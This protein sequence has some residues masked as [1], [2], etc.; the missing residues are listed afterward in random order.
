MVNRWLSRDWMT[1]DRWTIRYGVA[2]ALSLMA[3]VLML[4][5]DPY[6]YL[7]EASFL[8]FF[9]AVTISAWYG[10][11]GPGILT[12][13][14]SALF[15]NYFFLPPLES[16]EV[17]SAGLL[18]ML[19]FASQGVLI[20][21]LVGSLR[22]TK[23]RI[24]H[25]LQQ[26]QAV[27]LA[28]R[29]SEERYRSLVSILTSIVWTVDPEGR[30]IHPQ[31][32]WKSYTGQDW[33]EHRGWGWLEAIHPGDR[34]QVEAAWK[35]AQGQQTVYHTEGRIWHQASQQYRYFEARAVPLLS[36]DGT[37]REW[38]GTVQ[39]VDDRRRAAAEI[40]QLNQT[41]QRRVDELQTLFDVIPIGIAIAEDP[42]C[43]VVR[44]NPAF[45]ALLQIELSGN[46]SRTPPTGQPTPPFKVYQNGR[47][48]SPE[49]LPQ[50]YAAK[51]GVALNEVEVDIVRNDGAAFNLYGYVAPL[52][53][54]QGQS[55]GSIAA[56]LDITDRKRAEAA[57]QQREAELRLIT[58]S[59]PALIS[60]VDT[61]R[62]YR[63]V[64]R[65]YT[66]WFGKP[67][68]AIVG[69]S[70]EDF[71]GPEI[72]PLMHPHVE[73]ALAGQRVSAE[74]LM[75]FRNG[76]PR[77]VRRQY[78]PDVDAEGRVRGFYALINDIT[79]LKQV[80]AD[81][82]KTAAWLRLSLKV[83]SMGS[84][85]WNM[86]T[87]AVTWSEGHFTILGY[88]IN[89]C[90]P[91]YAA[92]ASRVHPDD[93]KAAE[94][95]V[96]QAI[97]QHTD[98][99][100]QHR[101]VWPDGSIHWVE[102]RG[103]IFYQEDDRPER[104][105]GVLVDITE[106]KQT[107][108]I[109]ERRAE[110]MTQL[111]YLLMSATA[112]L[113]QRNQ[114][115]DQ[116]AYVVS[117]DLKAPL[118]GIVNLAEWLKEE[119][120]EQ[121]SE[122]HQHLLQ[123]MQGRASRMQ[124]LINGLLEYSRIGRD[125]MPVETVNLEDLLADLVDILDPP[126]DYKV[127]VLPPLPTLTTHP[128]LMRQVFANLISNAIK[129]CDRPDCEITI[130]ASDQGNQYEFSV[131][132][133]GPGIDPRYHQKIFGIFQTLQ[134]RDKVESTGVG[135]SIVK[136][137]VDLEGGTVTVDSALGEGAT[138]RFTWPKGLPASTVSPAIADTPPAASA[139]SRTRPPQ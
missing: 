68:T 114:E 113:E 49:E 45:A 102:A 95:N 92:W 20:S 88:E 84:W 11:Y 74:L 83:S 8:L 129:H 89:G 17:S 16:F 13:L 86:Q 7:T 115:L 130:R 116:F 62:R 108:A 70:L 31:L 25:S 48:L 67:A 118:R 72:Y 42:D 76:G 6:L 100:N 4:A 32:A 105:V 38:V 27:D 109:L 69:Q 73:A 107:Q 132:D 64:N 59:V 2:I 97:A 1:A 111:N 71:V 54:E 47:E 124:E 125:E 104:M 33:A 10:G 57:L 103:Q 131:T 60:Y 135:L 133:N 127:Q 139:N 41:L 81:L 77:Y 106:Q 35:A 29:Q 85:D 96:Q 75:P 39:D 126:P 55:R 53:D 99:H 43:R 9:G 15:A 121:L 56:F 26:V 30:F 5:L 78:I 19:I 34:P 63:F 44:V 128:L 87:N 61:E 28:L 66:D 110:E 120:Y 79:D 91:S 112:N 134:P 22:R 23:E 46:A 122:D 117:H 50:Q 51:Y 37:V 21:F 58:D 90:Q 3:L 82:E 80:E 52:F 101:V 138:F 136:K 40:S 24:Q 119:A 14:L 123:L 12:T 18:R 36:P 98:Y 137:I 93:L 94:A 65:A